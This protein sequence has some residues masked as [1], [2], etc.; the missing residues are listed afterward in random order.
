LNNILKDIASH[1][2]KTKEQVLRELFEEKHLVRPEM[3]NEP[4]CVGYG[5]YPRA[6]LSPSTLSGIN[7]TGIA[8]LTSQSVIVLVIMASWLK[9]R[10]A[11][12]RV[13]AP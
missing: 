2:E 11:A 6:N 12:M 4:N 10:Q 13:S 8:W 5:S 1:L 3:P 9:R 7:S